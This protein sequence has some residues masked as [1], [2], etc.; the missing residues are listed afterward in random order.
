[1]AGQPLQPP[2]SPAWSQFPRFQ[3][4]AP[5]SPRPRHLLGAGRIIKTMTATAGA[6]F[7]TAIAVSYSRSYRPC[8]SHVIDFN[9]YLLRQRLLVML[10]LGSFPG[11]SSYHLPYL[12]G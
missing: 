7:E 1:V 10:V 12:A 11:M 5:E 8:S 6:A 2:L 4:N 9:S 3:S